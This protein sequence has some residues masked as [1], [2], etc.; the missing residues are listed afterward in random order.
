MRG[1]QLAREGD[2]PL[3]LLCL[4]AHSDDIEIGAGG[5]ILKLIASGVPIEVAW[6]VFSGGGARRA[7]A[8]ASASDFL[9]GAAASSICIANFE[10]SYFPLH[11]RAIKEWLIEQRAHRN[12]DII[13][14]HMRDDAHQDHR[15]INEL[16]WNIFRDHTILEYEIPK[17]DGDLNRT[18]SYV[19]LSEPIMER[20]IDLLMQHFG[21][22]RAKDWF[23]P[24]TF[25]GLARLRGMEC[26][27]TDYYAEA[28]IMRKFCLF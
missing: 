2:A 19:A 14:T 11:R 17:W 6:C 12:P 24:E 27:A 28:F 25:R 20:K 9:H 22:Q 4:G 3:K 8:Q 5:T 10:D 16:T 21:T 26:R 13:L 18:N 1:L 7:E 15:L 23:A